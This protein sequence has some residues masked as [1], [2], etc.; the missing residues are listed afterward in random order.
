MKHDVRRK[1]ENSRLCFVCGLKNDFGL[2]AAFYELENNELVAVFTPQDEH[3]SYPGRMH[4]GIAAAML[5]E[6][7][8]R[9]I[10][11]EQPEIWG[12][13]IDLQLK[14]KK[15]VPLEQELR[16][17]GRI[18]SQNKRVF[19]GSGELLLPDGTVAVVATGRYMKMPLDSIADFDYEAEEWRVVADDADPDFMEL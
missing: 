12:V 2:K 10:M 14:Y 6:T 17:V 19:E 9:A 1:H 11:I 7:I 16:V 3:Q 5:D 15:P 8:G 18:T 13:T 4:G